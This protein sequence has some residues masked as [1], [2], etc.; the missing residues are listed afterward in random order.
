MPDPAGMPYWPRALR[1]QLAAQYCGLSATTFRQV[2]MPSVAPVQLTTG[3]VAWLREDL[4]AWLDSRKSTPVDGTAAGADAPRS[5]VP[6]AADP[7]AEGLAHF[8]ATRR[9][10]RAHK[11]R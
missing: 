6:Y 5:E 10:R 8:E 3:R 7:V 11:A 2:V 9:A 1:E 4:D